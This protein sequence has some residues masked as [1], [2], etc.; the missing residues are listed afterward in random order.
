MNPGHLI[1]WFNGRL[2]VARGSEIWHSDA[3]YPGSTDE[4]KNFKQ[5][6]GYIS[7]MRAVKDGVYV[8]NSK[9][10]YFMAGLDPSEAS[11]VKVADYPAI[12]G[13]DVKIDGDHWAGHL[14]QAV[15]AFFNGDL[16]GLDGGRFIS[17]LNFYRHLAE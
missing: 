14:G 8:S 9:E 1:E 11:L 3:V 2:H 16:R 6:G 12:L 13:S 5:L 10:T 4:R 15:L 7:M 17:A